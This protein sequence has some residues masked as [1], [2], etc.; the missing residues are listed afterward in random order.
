MIV[1]V[2]PGADLAAVTERLTS[3][4]VTIDSNLTSIN[5]LVTAN[6]TSNNVILS[7]DADIVTVEANCVFSLDDPNPTDD[8]TSG[9]SGQATLT[10]GGTGLNGDARGFGF[11]LNGAV[12]PSSTQTSPWWGLDRIDSR[13]GRDSKYEYGTATG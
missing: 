1:S 8:D 4:G 12:T 10:D 5:A 7:A 13:S 11:G 6:D 9:M 3:Q 2:R